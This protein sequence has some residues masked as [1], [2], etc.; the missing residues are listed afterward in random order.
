MSVCVWGCEAFCIFLGRII[1]ASL[2]GLAFGDAMRCDAVG[3][4]G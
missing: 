2:L 3:S 1:V 4:C